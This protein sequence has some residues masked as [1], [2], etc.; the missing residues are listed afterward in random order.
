MVHEDVNTPIASSQSPQSQPSDKVSLD[1]IRFLE[2]PEELREFPSHLRDALIE[3]CSV[4]GFYLPSCV[5]AGQR[6]R[7]EST[8]DDVETQFRTIVT[9]QRL[10]V[11]RYKYGQSH[12]LTVVK[13]EA[14]NMINNGRA[15][16]IVAQ[17][18]AAPRIKDRPDGTRWIASY[19]HVWTPNFNTTLRTRNT[20]E[21]MKL[22]KHGIKSNN[23][24]QEFTPTDITRMS[25]RRHNVGR[26][27]LRRTKS[28]KRKYSEVTDS[29][30]SDTPLMQKQAQQDLTTA[31]RQSPNPRSMTSTT[32]KQAESP[33]AVGLVNTTKSATVN[34]SLQQPALMEKISLGKESPFSSTSRLDYQTPKPQATFV[35]KHTLHSNI[36]RTRSYTFCNKIQLLFAQARAAGIV[37][38][39]TMTLLLHSGFQDNNLSV[40][41]VRDDPEDFEVFLKSLKDLNS[42]STE[43]TVLP[44]YD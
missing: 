30:D 27:G 14:G 32:P 35:F 37:E 41:V 18:P 24:D 20:A 21:I 17:I 40:R 16:I 1:V 13:E 9:N 28:A 11:A 10:L 3:D 42:A 2:G 31:A 34:P 43:V 7:I 8:S 6:K 4:D 22:S 36:L 25:S 19:W 33:Q 39:S 29:S 5:R 23:R 44:D 15:A 12:H 26:Q 38:P